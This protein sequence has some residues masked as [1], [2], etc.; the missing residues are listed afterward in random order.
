VGGHALRST[1]V[2]V[3]ELISVAG[4]APRKRPLHRGQDLLG[5]VPVTNMLRCG[6][7]A[8]GKPPQPAHLLAAILSL[9][10]NRG[11]ACRPRSNNNKPAFVDA[12]EHPCCE[13]FSRL[14]CRVGRRKG[15]EVLGLGFQISWC[16]I[17]AY[18]HTNQQ[19]EH[20]HLNC[21]M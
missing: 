1:Y 19:D 8:P 16:T 12:A 10:A 20:F 2:G 5:L 15:T 17:P 18:T 7:C 4:L 14:R 9:L 3:Q 11:R 21:T 6:T 13:G